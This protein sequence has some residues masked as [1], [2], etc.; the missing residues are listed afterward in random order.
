[1]GRGI[2]G[3]GGRRSGGRG[4]G[5]GGGGGGTHPFSW[6]PRVLCWRHIDTFY[7]LNFQTSKPCVSLAYL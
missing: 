6:G 1:M 4:K 5:E 7:C 2:G 3:Y